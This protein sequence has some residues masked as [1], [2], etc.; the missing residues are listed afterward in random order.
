MELT[1][2]EV[3]KI[4]IGI[5]MDI[6]DATGKDELSVSV[7][8]DGFAIYV[9]FCGM[10]VWDSENDVREFIMVDTSEETVEPLEPFIR[11]QINNIIDEMKKI[12]L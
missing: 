12:T 11:R 1:L 10:P 5:Q 6:H 9:E 8:S 2:E 7:I 3:E 4:I